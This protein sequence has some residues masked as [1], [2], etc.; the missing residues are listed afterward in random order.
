MSRAFPSDFRA[1]ATITISRIAFKDADSYRT[2]CTPVEVVRT[3]EKAVLVK[4]GVDELWIPLSALTPSS[5]RRGYFLLAKWVSVTEA[6][7]GRLGA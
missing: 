3:T 1:G 7:A 5:N 6:W 2:H 4:E